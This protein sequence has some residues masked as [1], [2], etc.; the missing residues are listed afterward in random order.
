MGV[1]GPLSWVD[2]G[3]GALF[4]VGGGEWVGVGGD[5]CEKIEVGG[6]GWGWVHCL[7]YSTI[8]AKRYQLKL[9]K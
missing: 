3:G 4:W 1:S 7:K 5:E 2:G 8:F 9:I 6:S